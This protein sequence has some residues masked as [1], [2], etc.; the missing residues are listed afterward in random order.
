MN[1]ITAC[2]ICKNEE[3]HIG[4]CI[5]A[6]K[7]YD[8]AVVVTDTGSTD[9]TVSIVRSLL[10]EQD[11]LCH[12]TWCNDFSAARNFCAM[13]ADTDWLW[14]I[15]ADE[16]LQSCDLKALLH[17]IEVPANQ[18]K[19]G[20]ITQR[21]RYQLQGEQT[22]VRS[23]ETHIYHRQHYHY[24]GS[25]HEQLVSGSTETYLSNPEPQYSNPGCLIKNSL[26][27]DIYYDLPIFIEHLGYET[28]EISAQ[29][30]HRNI[31][32]LENAYEKE[33]DPYLAYQLGNAY[34]SLNEHETAIRYFEEGL[35]FDLDPALHY[36]QRMV[37]T[38]GYSLLALKQYDAALAFEGIYDAFAKTADF[39]FL[40]GLI[41][42][43]NGQFDRAIAEFE[44]A[45]VFQTCGVEGTNSYRALYN[46]GVILECTARIAD[47]ISAYRK[48]G[49]FEPAKKRL[50]VICKTSDIKSDKYPTECYNEYMKE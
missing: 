37:E 3:Q 44:K 22:Y 34:F 29:K 30:S 16:I 40:M 28:P 1:K 23:K 43:N 26:S 49:D 42:M 2:I 11:K 17:F 21:S 12:F 41:Y 9:Q 31:T 5:A 18:N 13:Q 4:N 33:H 20:V 27:S 15:D 38:Y 8:I 25:I 6:L 47:A 39:V 45:T 10:S 50:A 19:I 36:V 24:E 14:L 35:S 46:K 32:L 48:C 7:A